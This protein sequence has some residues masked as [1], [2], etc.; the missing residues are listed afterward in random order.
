MK[1][2]QVAAAVIIKNKKILIA[3]RKNSLC[4]NQG[5]EFPGGKVEP[6]ETFQQCLIREIKEELNVEIDVRNFIANSKFN[7]DNK[8]IHI[9]AFEAIVLSGIITPAEHEEIAFVKPDELLNYDLLP[10]D[11]PIA[12][13]IIRDCSV[14]F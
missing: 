9:K 2:I 13:K 12:K 8:I 6:G 5:W 1:T 4:G 3:R 7:A 11:I 14:S 10:A